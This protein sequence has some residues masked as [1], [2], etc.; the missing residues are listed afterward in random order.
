MLPEYTTN[1]PQEKE[2]GKEGLEKN[3]DNELRDDARST[4]MMLGCI[5]KHSRAPLGD[6]CL[7]SVFA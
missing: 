7:F 5:G 6:F 2:K 1:L 4:G 3:E